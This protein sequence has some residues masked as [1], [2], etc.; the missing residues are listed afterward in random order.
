[1]SCGVEDKQELDDTIDYIWARMCRH[2]A[3]FVKEPK[4]FSKTDL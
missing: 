4:D 3:H 1:M 2:L